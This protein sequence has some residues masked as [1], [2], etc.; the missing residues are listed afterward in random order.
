[1]SV[2]LNPDAKVVA[3][4]DKLFKP[5]SYDMRAYV[6]E[7]GAFFGETAVMT[8]EAMRTAGRLMG[9]LAFTL[10][11]GSTLQMKKGDTVVI[12]YDNGPTSKALADAYAEGLMS[13]GVN[14]FDIGVSSSGQ[15]YQNQNQLGAQ[16]HVQITRSHVEVTTN[17][18]KFGIGIQGI[19]TYLLKQMNSAL[20]NNSELREGDFGSHIGMRA[21]GRKKYFDKMIKKYKPYFQ[22]RDNSKLAV[23]LFGGTGLQYVDLFKEV[24][25]QDIKLLGLDI[26]VNAGDLLADPTR[27]EMI[28]RVPEFQKCLDDGYRIHSFDLD[29]DRGSVTQGA[30]ALML[31]EEGHYLGDSL[32]YLLAEYKMKAAVPALEKKLNELGV[33]KDKIE[34]IIEMASTIIIDPRYTS[35]IRKVV[36]DFGGET[37]FHPKGHSLWKET[38]TKNMLKLS[39]LAGFETLEDFVKATG[40]RDYQIEASLHFFTTDSED[41][42]PRDD[43]IEN[44]FILE[45]VFDS[46]GVTDLKEYFADA[47]KRF[48]TKEIRTVSDS[49]EVKEKITYKINSVLSKLFNKR[50][51]YSVVEFDG[52]IRVDWSD[53]YIMYGMSN[54][55]PKLTFMAEGVTKEIRNSALAFVLAL[56]NHY[57]SKYG[58]TAKMDFE[59]NDFFLKD[60]SYDLEAPDFVSF[61]DKYV[62]GFMENHKIS[63]NLID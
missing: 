43:S 42:I 17:G 1:M 41:G 18:A 39:E 58:D 7:P 28:S 16:G 10:E 48:M 23:N 11:D 22:S 51:G 59:E 36:S 19:H 40:Y 12:G 37:V 49:N 44:I 29:A 33:A 63:A 30:K 60:K 32:C 54:T 57:K 4:A 3:N 26:D 9:G 8:P 53:G 35:S 45:Q 25:G 47:E 21:E 55:S 56:H 13:V 38:V 24:F 20:K 34:Q 27:T 62:I 46:L 5:A 50:D 31:G 61:N 15:V 14:V 2:N 52:Q 6:G